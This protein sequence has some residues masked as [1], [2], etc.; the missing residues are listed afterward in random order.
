[1]RINELIVESQQIDELSLAGALGSA[2]KGA[3][4]VVGGAKGAWAGAKDVYNQQAGRVAN[5]AQRNVQRA[6]GYK[7]PQPTPAT[8]P[9]TPP[10]GTTPATAPVTPPTGT[11]PATA[12][13]T[14]PT[15]TTPATAPAAP[16]GR[17]GIPAGRQ[18]IDKA[19]ATINAV[20]G[21]RRPQVVAYGLQKLG[22]IKETKVGLQSNFLGIEI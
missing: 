11:T 2:A 4:N 15:G 8:A 14:P 18:A 13:V 17:L 5:V 12:P 21:D 7:A 6:G 22:A 9:V 16:E 3:A 20:R 1:M 10:T 19:V